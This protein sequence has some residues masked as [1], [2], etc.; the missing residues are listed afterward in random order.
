MKTTSWTF[1]LP[2]GR[3][4][5]LH[6]AQPTPPSASGICARPPPSMYGAQ[7]THEGKKQNKKKNNRTER[8]RKTEREKEKDGERERC[9]EVTKLITRQRE[10][11]FYFFVDADDAAR[12]THGLGEQAVLFPRRYHAGVRV[13]RQGQ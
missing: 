10:R 3:M 13:G 9:R 1:P 2:R 7:A 5:C 12:H 8:R 4:R 6:H 11:I